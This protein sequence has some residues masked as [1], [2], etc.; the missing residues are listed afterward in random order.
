MGFKIKEV[1]NQAN[2]TQEELAQRSG[3]ARTIIAGLESGAI[4]N[5]STKTLVKLARALQKPV[6]DI[7]FDEVV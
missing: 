3:V 2:M 7:F 6:A 5:T 1:R 4:K